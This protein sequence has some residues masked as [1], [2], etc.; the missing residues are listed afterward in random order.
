ML[1]TGYNRCPEEF[2]DLKLAQILMI[3]NNLF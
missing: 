1:P 3:G 2:L